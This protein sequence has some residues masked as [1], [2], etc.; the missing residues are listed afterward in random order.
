MRRHVVLRSTPASL[1]IFSAC[2]RNVAA[3]TSKQGSSSSGSDVND[4]HTVGAPPTQFTYFEIYE[5]SDGKTHFRDINV[6]LKAV[7]FAPPAPPVGMGELQPATRTFFATT[8]ANWGRAD[9]EAGVP[10]PTPKRQFV[11]ALSGTGTVITSDGERRRIV[12]G[13][14]V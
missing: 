3:G 1:M 2:S 14:V 9:Y 11:V 12:P 6:D 10:H 8:G 7:N 4:D 13:T 5:G